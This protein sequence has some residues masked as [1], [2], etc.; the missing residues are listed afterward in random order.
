MRNKDYELYIALI[1]FRSLASVI[2]NSCVLPTIKSEKD[3][4]LAWD[5]IDE[6]EASIKSLFKIAI[7]QKFK[8]QGKYGQPINSISL[9]PNYDN[10]KIHIQN[11]K[12]DGNIYW[13]YPIE[14]CNK[15]DLTLSFVAFY[16]FDYFNYRYNQ[17][18]KCE[19]VDSRISKEI[20]G[21]KAIIEPGLYS[22]R[23][24]R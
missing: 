15:R 11:D 2:Y 16:D 19:I 5:L 10:A 8:I 7:L 3:F 21:K 23:F 9:V 22:V 14:Q 6:Y 13:D 4:N 17:Y 12:K 20:I 24:K 18:I 1:E